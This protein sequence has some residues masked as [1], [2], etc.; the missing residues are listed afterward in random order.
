MHFLKN[1][2]IRLLS[3][4]IYLFSTF[5]FG[6]LLYFFHQEPIDISLLERYKSTKPTILLDDNGLEWARFEIDKR[7]YVKLVNLP[8]H[9]INAFLVSEDRNF[10]NHFGLS[11]RGIARSI[12]RNFSSG[13]IVQGAS[14]ITQ[15][16]V[17]LLYFDSKKTYSR[18]IKELL[19]SLLIEHYYTKEQILETYL[20]HVYFGCGIYGVEA[21]CQ[22]FWGMASNDINISQSAMLAAIIQCPGLYCPLINPEKALIR[23]NLILDSMFRLNYFDKV[24][25]DSFLKEPLNCKLLD[26]NCCAPHAKEN[27]RQQLEK[28]YG[29]QALYTQGLIVQ[30]T[31]N[32]D[33]Q[34]K[35]L[36]EFKKQIENLRI[37]LDKPLDG[38]LVIIDSETGQIKALVGGYNFIDSKFNRAIQAKRQLGSIFKPFVYAKALENGVS[39][40]DT[41]YDLPLQISIAGNK[42]WSPLN[43]NHKFSGLMTLARGL[44]YSNNIISIKAL[45]IAGAKNVYD[46]AKEVNLSP[47]GPFYSLA[48][49]CLDSTL[50]D[51]AAAFNVF[52]NHGVFVKPNLIKWI[53]NERGKKIWCAQIEQKIIFDSYISDQV[54]SVLAIGMERFKDRNKAKLNIESFGKTGTTNDSRTNWFCGATSKLTTAIYIGCDDNQS[55]GVNIYPVKTA[56]PIWL[57]IHQDLDHPAIKYNPALEK[58]KIDWVSGKLINNLENSLESVEIR[59]AANRANSSGQSVE[60]D[61]PENLLKKDLDF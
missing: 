29:R 27:I 7:N 35:S 36:K 60:P 44:S 4:S 22:R 15:Q 45:A 26:N 17:K 24:D 20:N 34:N 39:L 50:L 28:N 19:V 8:K 23:R 54:I 42:I 13:K 11:W 53:K 40:I 30:T 37:S 1:K 18:K 9:L 61:I 56:F 48:L 5:I 21:A 41:V 58:I 14:T 46:V 38:G 52:T 55:L 43:F 3:F 59:V 12:L 16:L 31:L 6:F 2:Y 49:G 51:M 32:K 33:L 25:L 57:N 47:V 10:Y